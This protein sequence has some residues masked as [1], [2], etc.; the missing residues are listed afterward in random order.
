MHFLHEPN[1]SGRRAM[2]AKQTSP[3]QP[4][5]LEER[6]LSFRAVWRKQNVHR[7]KIKQTRRIPFSMEEE[8]FGPGRAAR[9]R[10][11]CCTCHQDLRTDWKFFGA[12]KKCNGG[13]EL[14]MPA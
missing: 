10:L 13:E 12:G 14:D 3:V 9:F 7:C 11:I 6:F 4:E 8:M 2:I 5:I 1:A